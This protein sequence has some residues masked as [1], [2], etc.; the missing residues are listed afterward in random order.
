VLIRLIGGERLI[1][2]TVSFLMKGVAVALSSPNFSM[3]SINAFLEQVTPAPRVCC[4]VLVLRRHAVGVGVT[5]ALSPPVVSLLFGPTVAWCF[6]AA[7]GAAWAAAATQ[8]FHARIEDLQGEYRLLLLIPGDL[9]ERA[10]Q[11][12][13][14]WV[15]ATKT[16]AVQFVAVSLFQRVLRYLVV[17]LRG[18]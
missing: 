13:T 15:S 8:F 14:R 7:C 1:T 16:R 9:S 5:A 17:C 6:G 18:T 2:T 10:R 12:L 11:T 4:A 3:S